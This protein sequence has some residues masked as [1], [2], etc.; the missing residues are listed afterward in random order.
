MHGQ[1]VPPLRHVQGTVHQVLT[2][3]S[4][5]AEALCC[6]APGC[7][8]CCSFCKMA[9]LP[10][11][12][13]TGRVTAQLVRNAAAHLFL[14]ELAEQM[15]TGLHA[16]WGRLESPG[17]RDN[18]CAT[19]SLWPASILSAREPEVTWAV[20]GFSSVLKLHA[21][22]AVETPHSAS[23]GLQCKHSDD[24]IMQSWQA[25]VETALSTLCRCSQLLHLVFLLHWPLCSLP[26]LR[27]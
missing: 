16:Y 4:S 26:P 24:T 20:I 22:S 10:A 11:D 9:A 21:Y 27:C 17:F 14:T 3:K 18:L 15:T 5:P 25:V 1:V 6:S 23:S 2:C 12:A 8:R 7:E 13:Q 19:V